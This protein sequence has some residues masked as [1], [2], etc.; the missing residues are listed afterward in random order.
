MKKLFII[1][2][3]LIASLSFSQEQT[4]KVYNYVTVVYTDNT[5]ETKQLETR[6]FV[7][8]GG[9][10]GAMKMYMANS[11]LNMRQVGSVVTGATQS[12]NNY[13]IYTM[14]DLSSGEELFLQFFPDLDV[15]RMLFNNSDITF[16]FSN[17]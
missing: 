5:T 3:L 16:E 13:E 2:M 9:E 14:L 17:E 12:G 4:L 1:G 10:V 6:F 7:N 15:V 11:V 8:Y